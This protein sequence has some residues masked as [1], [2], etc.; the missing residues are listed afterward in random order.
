MRKSYVFLTIL[1]LVTQLS[2]DTMILTIKPF[3]QFN[4]EFADTHGFEVGYWPH[5]AFSPAQVFFGYDLGLLGNKG[6]AEVYADVQ[7]GARFM[8]VGAGVY[9]INEE[10]LHTGLQL[11]AWFNALLGINIKGRLNSAD[12]MGNS[13]GFYFAIPLVIKNK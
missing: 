2:A 8:G 9:L 6:V 13:V 7:L 3:F 4:D 1:L 10:R 12:P 5:H 11:N